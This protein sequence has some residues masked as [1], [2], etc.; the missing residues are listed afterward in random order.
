MNEQEF[1]QRFEHKIFNYSVRMRY[2]S[3]IMVQMA[4][5][6]YLAIIFA[7]DHTLKFPSN[8]GFYPDERRWEFDE[9]N[10]MILFKDL[11]NTKVVSRYL[12]PKEKDDYCFI[13]KNADDPTKIYIAHLN[14]D[15]NV[16]AS[17]VSVLDKQ[18]V[19]FLK[20]NHEDKQAWAKL[21]QYEIDECCKIKHLD[22][23]D[24]E[25]DYVNAAWK[26]A[27]EDTEIKQACVFFTSG[28]STKQRVLSDKLIMHNP[29]EGAK[30]VSGTRG[31]V[32][33]VLAQLLIMHY[34]EQIMEVGQL[35][36]PVELLNKVALN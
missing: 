16:E 25:W 2:G 4:S 19:I 12:L 13:L 20:N 23:A 31:D 8:I 5:G 26:A 34:H 35:H 11:N 36:S 10:Q 14:Y 21:A 28:L 24:D 30:F 1:L 9:Q 33:V 3:W 6:G 7:R 27:V 18:R 15:F 29:D 22:A 32:I 17:P